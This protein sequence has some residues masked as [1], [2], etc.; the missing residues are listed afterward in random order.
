VP[1][2]A[3]LR[4]DSRGE[5]SGSEILTGACRPRLCLV[6]ASIPLVSPRGIAGGQRPPWGVAGLPPEPPHLLQD[7]AATAGQ[8]REAPRSGHP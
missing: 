5:F 2:I 7:T 1:E 8:G 6:T 3:W 4:A